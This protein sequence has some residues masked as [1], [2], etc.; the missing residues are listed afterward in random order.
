MKKKEKLYYTFKEY[1]G[2]EENSLQKHEYYNGEI[3]E[4]SG[5]SLEHSIIGDNL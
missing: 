2:F 4:M 1:L 5:G 3:L